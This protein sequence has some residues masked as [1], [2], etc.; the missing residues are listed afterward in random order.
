[1]GALARMRGLL[2]IDGCLDL[3]SHLRPIIYDSIS[4]LHL[5]VK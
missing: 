2:R 3:Q 1:L 4:N 5:H